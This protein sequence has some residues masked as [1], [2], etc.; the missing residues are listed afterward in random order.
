MREVVLLQAMKVLK[1]WLR[2]TDQRTLQHIHIRAG[3]G[4]LSYQIKH[5]FTIGECKLSS[6][7]A[8]DL[9]EELQ[10]THKWLHTPTA[11]W[12]FHLP[13]EFG[14]AQEM[15]LPMQLFLSVAEHFR[16]AVLPS[17]QSPLQPPL[18]LLPCTTDELREVLEEQ[19][20]ADEKRVLVQMAELG[21]IS[22]QIIA[23]LGLSR[24]VA[25][26][27]LQD[28]RDKRRAQC[29]LLDVPSAARYKTITSEG[30]VDTH[31]PIKAC[32][33][34]DSFDHMLA[35]YDLNAQLE[36]GTAAVPFLVRLA[37]KTQI[38]DLETPR[39]F[40]G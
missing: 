6:V 28:L 39:P 17:V 15:D 3:E 37:R 18:P 23:L 13:G 25:Q 4:E 21:S 34:R 2:G 30:L 38:L 31:C 27:A 22:A 12:P 11:L 24:S 20:Q 8:S 14:D 16:I 1:D 26:E 9:V 36:R 19:F 10:A 29:N 35:C 7:V 5:W 33:S 32:G 40:R